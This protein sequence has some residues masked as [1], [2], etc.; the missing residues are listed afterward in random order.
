MSA[1]LETNKPII[2]GVLTTDDIVQAKKRSDPD[3]MNKGS[4]FALT[5]MHLAATRYS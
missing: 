2:C 5:A 4:E 1:S 3:Q